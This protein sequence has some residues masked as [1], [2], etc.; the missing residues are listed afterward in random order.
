MDTFSALVASVQR[1]L[2]AA[3]AEPGAGA[4]AARLASGPLA[5]PLAALAVAASS[6]AL[7]FVLPL[8]PPAPTKPHA[9]FGAFYAQYLREHSKINT[10]RLHF[11]GTALMLAQVAVRPALGVAIACGGL[12]GHSLF[13]LL[14]SHA[15]GAVEFVAM[16]L[17]YAA[18]GASLTGSPLRTALVPLSAYGLAWAGH[19]FVERN[20][21]ATFIYPTFSLMGDLRMF[22]EMLLLR[23]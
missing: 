9:T 16:L 6:T 12:V 18:V 21:P 17:T 10:R 1:H 8:P 4:A 2:A 3:A 11:A 20:R 22:T 5:A 13:P 23:R 7:S 15:T 14:R 19:F